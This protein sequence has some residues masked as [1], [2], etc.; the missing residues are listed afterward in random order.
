MR[1]NICERKWVGPGKV[2]RAVR[3]VYDASLTL[4]G[5]ERAGRLG[6]SILDHAAVQGRFGKAIGVL[7]AMKPSRRIHVSLEWACLICLLYS[8]TG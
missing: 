8:G 7:E 5:G 3:H 2:G 4:S 1:A 6:G